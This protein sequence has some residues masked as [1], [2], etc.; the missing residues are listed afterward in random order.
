MISDKD[1][2]RFW[3]KVEKRIGNECWAW[4]SCKNKQGY[5]TFWLNGKSARSSRV[6]WTLLNGEIPEG[7]FVCHS[8]DNPSC[9]NPAHLFIGTPLENTADAINKKRMAK[10]RVTHCPNGHEYSGDNLRHRNNGKWR[11]CRICGRDERKKFVEKNR[12]D[13]NARRREARKKTVCHINI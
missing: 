8:C 13:I 11:R 4:A 1:L 7:C 6:M 2:T 10:Q 12:D 5:G 9:V 3:N